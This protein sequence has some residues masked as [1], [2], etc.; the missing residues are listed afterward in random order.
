MK[1]NVVEVN[2]VTTHYFDEGSGPVVVLLHGAALGIDAEFTWFRQIESL[3]GSHRV[4]AFDQPGFG[5]TSI[6]TDGFMGRAERAD[7]AIAFLRL[8]GVTNAMMIGHSEGG[9]IAT[10]IAIVAPELI[11]AMIVVTSGS[12]A[13]MLGGSADDAWIAASTAT[14]TVGDVDEE[15]YIAGLRATAFHWDERMERLAR[16]SIRRGLEGGHVAMMQ[17]LPESELDMH[18]Y[19]Q[20]QKETV[21]PHLH[22]ILIPTL[23]VWAADDRTVPLERG[24]ALMRAIPGSDLVVLSGTAHNVMHDRHAAFDMTVRNWLAATAAGQIQ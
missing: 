8:L 7:H 10:R 19:M 5:R 15:R 1:G 22:S 14:Y 16:E 18:L 21:E 3:K 2:G 13:P 20:V 24:V 6:P 11:S 17:N 9:Y 12:T 23:L 4:I